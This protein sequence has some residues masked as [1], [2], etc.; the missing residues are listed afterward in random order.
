MIIEV[1]KEKSKW[2]WRVRSKNGK[3]F[4]HSETYY[5]K[6]NAIRSAKSFETCV[7]LEHG[8]VEVVNG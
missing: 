1:V 3:T 2:F 8:L 5:N 6:S 7:K 4:C